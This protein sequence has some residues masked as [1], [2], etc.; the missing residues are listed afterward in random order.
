MGY[1]NQHEGKTTKERNP[2][3]R[4][5]DCADRMM[6]LDENQSLEDGQ[7]QTATFVLS[8]SKVRKYP[9]LELMSNNCSYAKVFGD[10]LLVI[11]DQIIGKIFYDDL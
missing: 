8:A 5:H 7:N 10:F 2:A 4:S 3:V 6:F 1:S 11:T 9:K